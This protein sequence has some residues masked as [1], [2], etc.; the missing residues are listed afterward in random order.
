MIAKHTMLNVKCVE[1]MSS[2]AWAEHHGQNIAS[3]LDF[4]MIAWLAS[5]TCDVDSEG[6]SEVPVAKQAQNQ[7]T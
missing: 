6:L 3:A 4:H 2:T 7:P 1:S 5:S